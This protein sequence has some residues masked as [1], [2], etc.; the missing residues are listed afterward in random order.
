MSHK[1]GSYTHRC[2]AE[3]CDKQVPGNVLMCY[4]H[5]RLVPP[6]ARRKL[7][8]A[9]VE[10]DKNQ[11]DPAKRGAYNAARVAAIAELARAIAA[12]AAVTPERGR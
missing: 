12:D 1:P 11:Y 4:P 7:T 3:S 2:A 5:W 9:W 6:P 8:A 10:F